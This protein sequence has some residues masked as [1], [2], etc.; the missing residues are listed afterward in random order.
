M[1]SRRLSIVGQSNTEREL[2]RL[3]REILSGAPPGTTT[4]LQ[5]AVEVL[6]T[7]DEA[8]QYI[9]SRL[10]EYRGEDWSSWYPE[11][12]NT[13]KFK[14][15]SN[16]YNHQNKEFQRYQTLFPVEKYPETKLFTSLYQYLAF[17]NKLLNENTTKNNMNISKC[18]ISPPSQVK[19]PV[20][21][22]KYREECGLKGGKGKTRRGKKSKRVT[23]RR[24]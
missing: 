3:K 24:R 9:Q 10:N 5:K 4:A 12:I 13:G 18:L 22:R 16:F 8:K 15:L 2:E 21:F 14:S 17:E 20:G 7:P 23:R 11:Y 6:Q 1:S 19:D